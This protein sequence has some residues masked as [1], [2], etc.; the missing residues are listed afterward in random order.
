MALPTGFERLDALLPGGGI[1]RGR[2]TELLGTRGSG[3]TTVLRQLVERTLADGRWVAWIDATRTL[4]PGEWARTAA[5]TR[6]LWIIRPH[7]AQRTAWCADVLLR[8]GAFALVV[9]DGA[10]LLARTVVARLSHL[11]RDHHA[12]LVCLGSDDQPVT[13]GGALRLRVQ[14]H[15]RR[16]RAEY[17]RVSIDKGAPQRMMEVECVVVM[18]HRLCAHPEVPDRRGV[19]RRH[20]ATATA[21]AAVAP[22]AAPAPAATIA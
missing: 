19:A 20:G 11:A 7:D 15:R 18:A 2:L 12:A 21:T 16:R 14:R 17:I 6:G 9:L 8:S 5:G 3:R 13:S 22:A 4:A 10:P 1:P